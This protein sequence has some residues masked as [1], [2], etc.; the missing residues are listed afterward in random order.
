VIDDASALL[1]DQLSEPKEYVSIVEAISAGFNTVTDIARLAA[2]ERTA[3][4]RYLGTLRKLGIVT[5]EV[6]AL[7]THPE[8]SRQGRYVITD[9]Y[10][11]WYYKF[12]GNQRASL[13][14]GTIDVAWLNI[15]K[16]LPAFV[17]EHIFEELCREYFWQL[18]NA[19]R[20]MFTPRV[21]GAYWGGKGKP[22]IDV[23][24]INEDAHALILGECKWQDK[25]VTGDTVRDAIARAQKI[26]PEPQSR[27][28]VSYAFFSK[29]GFTPDARGAAKGYTSIWVTLE[30]LDAILREYA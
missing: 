28:T 18:G 1:R 22:Q 2:L 7:E 17:G 13:E 21:V 8:K 30:R 3:L 4:P 9:H 25:P 10:L 24:A 29:G 12:L 20:L 5:R 11:R 27:W 26:I 23:V 14:R 15:R 16:H 19:G 6:P